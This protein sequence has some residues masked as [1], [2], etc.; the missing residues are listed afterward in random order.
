MTN[1]TYIITAPRERESIEEVKLLQ[2]MLD[3]DIKK[4]IIAKE[5]G[6]D[7]YKHWQIRLRSRYTWQEMKNKFGEK[8][9]IEE[10]SDD[11][12]YERKEGKFISSEDNAAILRTR[13][14]ELRPNQRRILTELGNSNDRSICCVVDRKGCTG[15]SFLARFLFERG[16]AFYVPPTCTT[17][18][19]IIQFVASGYR[20]EQIIVVDIPRSTRWNNQLYIAIECIKDGLVYDTRYHTTIRDIFGVN[21]L[22]LCNNKPNLSKLSKD[23]WHLLDADGMPYTDKPKAV[24]ERL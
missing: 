10:A 13:F 18:Q 9:H 3:N 7:G 20:N 21:V 22:V 5:V 6:N 12:K 8:A 2:W 17:A 1:K 24:K 14:G 11:W 4:W 15:K 19:S 23:R 16:T